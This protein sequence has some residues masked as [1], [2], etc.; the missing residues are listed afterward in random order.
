V[1]EIWPR[2]GSIRGTLIELQ[3]ANLDTAIE[4]KLRYRNG[5]TLSLTGA[6]IQNVSETRCK[7]QIP[8]TA[9]IGLA[10][11]CVLRSYTPSG[12]TATQEWSRQ[13]KGYFVL[14]KP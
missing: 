9:P 5:I 4:V 10:Q 11:V 12:G 8:L 13:Y 1:A 7:V 14:D 2:I 6:A 3:G